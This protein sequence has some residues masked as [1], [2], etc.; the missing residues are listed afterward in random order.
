MIVYTPWS[1][2]K[3]DGS[4]AVGQV[5]FKDHKK[6]KRVM[7]EKRE[8][9]IINRLNKTKEERYSDLAMEREEKLKVERRKE[10]MANEE[11]VSCV[12]F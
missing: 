1:N 2:L 8:N 12:P 5:G 7:V 4:M 11:R 6:V 10:R 9:T 3:K